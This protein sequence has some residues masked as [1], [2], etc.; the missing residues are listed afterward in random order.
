M[1]KCIIIR[2]DDK[3]PV[4][5]SIS[6]AFR[7]SCILFL[8]KSW[9][10]DRQILLTPA[11][12][13]G[14]I[15]TK[16]HRMVVRDVVKSPHIQPFPVKCEE[17]YYSRQSTSTSL[18]VST[19]NLRDYLSSHIFCAFF[20]SQCWYQLHDQNSYIALQSTSNSDLASHTTPVRGTRWLLSSCVYTD[21]ETNAPSGH[22]T[23]SESPSWLGTGLAPESGLLSSNAVSSIL[24]SM[25]P[26]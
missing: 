17:S 11:L 1:L 8:Y 20:C 5:P 9:T 22:V 14:L 6:Q 12:L 13:L 19:Y 7:L 16:W 23:Y 15:V 21:L 4:H 26:S 25:L 10:L 24:P 18:C 2:H 3:T